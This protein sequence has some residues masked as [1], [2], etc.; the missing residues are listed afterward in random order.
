MKSIQV[1]INAIG[2]PTFMKCCW[3]VT[4]YSYRCNEWGKKTLF[5]RCSILSALFLEK[6][7][8]R[9][10]RFFLKNVLWSRELPTLRVGRSVTRST[11]YWAF[12]SGYWLANTEIILRVG[13]SS[14]KRITLR[15]GSF[16]RK[17]VINNSYS[18]RFFHEKSHTELMVSSGQKEERLGEKTHFKMNKV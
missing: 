10:K 3:I 12:S 1:E 16:S 17:R 7:S 8:F 15:A 18:R 6:L 4:S 2:A 11:V 13:S 14:M 5:W 9:E